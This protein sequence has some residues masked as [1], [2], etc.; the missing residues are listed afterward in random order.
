MTIKTRGDWYTESKFRMVWS[1]TL[2]SEE[3]DFEEEPLDFRAP[4]GM[5]DGT[6][7][8]FHETLCWN[9]YELVEGVSHGVIVKDGQFEPYSTDRAMFEAVARS[10]GIPEDVISNSTEG[11]F[12]YVFIEELVWHPAT[13]R[14][15]VLTGS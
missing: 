7:T 4:E 6:H 13:Q 5:P 11:L 1:I 2:E 10:L 8:V 14:L 15:Q 3:T 9:T 12:D